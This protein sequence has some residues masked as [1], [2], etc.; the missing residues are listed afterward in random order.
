MSRKKWYILV[1]SAALS[2]SGA[3]AGHAFAAAAKSNSK[4]KIDPFKPVAKKVTTKVT[5]VKKAVTVAA[6]AP[7]VAAPVV[8]AAPAAPVAPPALVVALPKPIVLPTDLGVATAPPVV[9][10][11]VASDDSTISARPPVR[12][13]FRPPTRSPFLP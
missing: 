12:T 6:K 9:L 10:A 13:P 4:A 2:V 8:A 11:P 1:L 3:Y 5:V 7:V